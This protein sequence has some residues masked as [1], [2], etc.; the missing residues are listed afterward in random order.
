MSGLKE[1]IT[2]HAYYFLDSWEMLQELQLR[3]T[4][5]SIFHNF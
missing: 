5:S 4:V 3:I 1:Q 2:D